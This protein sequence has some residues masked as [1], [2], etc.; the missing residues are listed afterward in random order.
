[1]TR[2]TLGLGLHEDRC[3]MSFMRGLW[4]HEDWVMRGLG[5]CEERG[6]MRLHEDWG[7][8]KTCLYWTIKVALIISVISVCLLC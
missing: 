6:Y 3:Y 5:L 8:S 4:L 1:V 7:Y 2:I